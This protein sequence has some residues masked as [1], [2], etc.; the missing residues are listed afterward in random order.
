MQGGR[1]SLKDIQ[2]ALGFL[3]VSTNHT[4]PASRNGD[5]TRECMCHWQIMM[6]IRNAAL[7]MVENCQMAKGAIASSCGTIWCTS[8][9]HGLCITLETLQQLTSPAAFVLSNGDAWQ[10][11]LSRIT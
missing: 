5:L 10:G 11:L 3:A 6:Q 9:K 7:K 8:R 4:C 2:G 1:A